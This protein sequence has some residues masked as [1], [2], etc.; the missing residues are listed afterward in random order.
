MAQYI[1]EPLATNGYSGVANADQIGYS[2]NEDGE[3]VQSIKDKIEELE[4]NGGNS[5][6]LNQIVQEVSL[7]TTQA[8]VYATTAS[9]AAAQA[10]SSKQDAA[11]AQAKAEEA[12][13]ET[14][15]LLQNTQ[16]DIE[17][18]KNV[19]NNFGGIIDSPS[20]FV[21]ITEEQYNSLASQENGLNNDTIYFCYQNNL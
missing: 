8:Q 12:K 7:Q 11:E 16:N 21:I 5:E 4:E 14:E 2:Y 15:A 3:I 18:I 13:R 9:N 6:E 10:I 17:E 20:Q 1:T 19:A